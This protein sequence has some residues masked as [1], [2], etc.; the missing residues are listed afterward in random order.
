MGMQRRRV[1]EQGK[2]GLGGETYLV[3]V[4]KGVHVEGHV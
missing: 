4:T 3:N 1:R 2:K